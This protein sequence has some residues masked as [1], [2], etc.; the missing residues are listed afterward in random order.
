MQPEPVQK[1]VIKVMSQ[2]SFGK[3]HGLGLRSI[4]TLRTFPDDPLPSLMIPG[5][6]KIMIPLEEGDAWMARRAQRI[7]GYIPGTYYRI[8]DKK[9]RSFMRLAKHLEA[10]GYLR[11]YAVAQQLVETM[12]EEIEEAR[13]RFEAERAAAAGHD[14][15]DDEAESVEV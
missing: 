5:K 2:E 8:I 13:V 3:R 4:Q 11:T 1:R 6:Y 10:A 7:A 14:D 9:I 12:K 15:N